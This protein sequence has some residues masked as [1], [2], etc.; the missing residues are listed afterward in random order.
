MSQRFVIV[1]IDPGDD[2]GAVVGEPDKGKHALGVFRWRKS[3]AKSGGYNLSRSGRPTVRVLTLHDV[4]QAIADFVG[5]RGCFLVCEGLFVPRPPVNMAKHGKKY[6]GQVRHVLTLA[7]STAL[8]YGPCLPRA[9]K[10]LRPTAAVWRP[11]ILGLS[12]NA[13]SDLSEKRAIMAMT[14]ARPP[15]VAG[16]GE[17]ATDPHVAEAACIYR[18]GHLR[19]VEGSRSRG[20]V[21][22]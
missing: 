7:E 4:G 10:L 21:K 8:L 18:W 1:A 3:E 22:S 15:L 5:A 6:T 14:Q 12:P 17:W 20:R 13:S 19:Q 9:V 2:G 11:E 16:L